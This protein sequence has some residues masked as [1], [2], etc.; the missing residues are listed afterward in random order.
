MGEPIFNISDRLVD[1][2]VQLDAGPTEAGQRQAGGLEL[3]AHDIVRDFLAAMLEQE[4]GLHVRVGGITAIRA[5]QEL[6]HGLA[7]ETA[8]LAVR[9]SDETVEAKFGGQSAGGHA[10]GGQ[11]RF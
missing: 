6:I 7:T 1:A 8:A 4:R 10:L 2:A 9:Q 3:V 11:P 5:V